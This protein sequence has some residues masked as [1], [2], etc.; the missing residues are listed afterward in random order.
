MKRNVISDGKMEKKTKI[1]LPSSV[2]LSSIKYVLFLVNN[3]I[4][5]I[6]PKI[7][8][9][10]LQEKLQDFQCCTI[11]IS[12]VNLSS[13]TKVGGMDFKISSRAL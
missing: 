10:K 12:S 9:N 8:R 11:S 2:T 1:K 3:T 4:L 13:P 7:Q 5:F 6:L